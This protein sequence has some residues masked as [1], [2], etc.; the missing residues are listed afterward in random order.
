MNAVIVGA[1]AGLGRA[2]AE[3]LASCG[4]NLYLVAS[5]EEDLA[6]LVS[7]LRL[8]FDIEAAFEALDL[9]NMT[10]GLCDRSNSAI[11]PVDNLFIVAGAIST[12]DYPPME[13]SELHRIVRINFEAPLLIINDFLES[14]LSRP[15]AN[16]VGIGTIA[17]ARARSRNSAYAAAKT[18][19]ESYFSSLRHAL[20]KSR[21]RV[22]FYRMGFLSTSMTFGKRLL[23]PPV[24]PKAAAKAIVAGLDGDRERQYFPGWW[25]FICWLYQSIPWFI[26]RKLD[27]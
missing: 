11:G 24:S 25:K 18:G 17:S 10:S 5:D 20:S 3:E 2:L 1:S 15:K 9:M 21:C 12:Q 27:I 7:D 19:L 14:I 6:P 8:R 22:Q 26:F 23:F 16:I 4:A 13:A